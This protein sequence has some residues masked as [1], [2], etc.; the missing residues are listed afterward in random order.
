MSDEKKA[1]SISILDK[2]YQV[3]CP[4]GEQVALLSSARH[5]DQRMREVRD[6]TRIV[7]LE[8][9]A[10]MAALNVTNDF[11][12]KDADSSAES[13]YKKETLDRIHNKLDNAL[14][15]FGSKINQE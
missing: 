10:V 11:L 4:V 6:N 12:T 7:G 15:K 2:Q 9:V 5:L 3:A 14:S 1:I 13:R 8:R